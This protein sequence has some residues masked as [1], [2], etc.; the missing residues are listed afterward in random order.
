MAP[1]RVR[2]IETPMTRPLVGSVETWRELWRKRREVRPLFAAMT[3][4]HTLIPHS[5]FHVK[6]Y[7]LFACDVRDSPSIDETDPEI[8]PA[9]PEDLDLFGAF[10]VTEGITL[11]RSVLRAWFLRGARVWIIERGS[12]LVAC[13]WLDTN[14]SYYLY[15]WL[16]LKASPKD[17][18]ALGWW[19]ARDH[20][21][22]GLAARI[23]RPGVSACAH[24]GYTR[25][26][27]AVD[28][29]NHSSIRASHK[30]GC[31]HIGRFFV[32]R[33]MGFTL[34]HFGRTLRLGRWSSGD[35]LELPVAMCESELR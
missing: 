15:D 12:R 7:F 17:V 9:T 32:L 4:L 16:V 22:Q 19:V 8:R 11:P 31:K 6:G 26:L 33:I 18:W 3:L 14:S 35:P 30:V 5:L 23:R 25:I 28:M 34:I 13:Y 2:P 24:A 29:L 1:S 20:R 27:G 10:E 21:G